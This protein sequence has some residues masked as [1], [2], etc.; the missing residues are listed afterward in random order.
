MQSLIKTNGYQIENQNLDDVQ[1][2]ETKKNVETLKP[3]DA[4]I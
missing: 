2:E 4:Q 3:R 1:F